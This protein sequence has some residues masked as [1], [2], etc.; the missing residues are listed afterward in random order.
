MTNIVNSYASNTSYEVDLLIK[1]RFIFIEITSFN[2]IPIFFISEK[3]FYFEKHYFT[4][5]RFLKLFYLK[6]KNMR[7]SFLI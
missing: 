3:K 5:Y 7:I 2:Q 4:S 6:N 1:F